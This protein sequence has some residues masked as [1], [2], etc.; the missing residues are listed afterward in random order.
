MK[1]LVLFLLS[2]SV[3]SPAL[4]QTPIDPLKLPQ[5]ESGSYI[6]TFGVNYTPDGQQRLF[7]DEFG[8]P[9]TTTRFDQ[10][11]IFSVSGSYSFN[12][13]ISIAGGLNSAIFFRSEKDEFADSNHRHTETDTNYSGALSLEYRLAPKGALDPRISFGVSYPWAA[14]VQGSASLLKDPVILSA[15]LGYYKSL[16]NSGDSLT[17]GL[18]AGFVANEKITFSGTANYTVPV[19][20]TDLPVTSIG[21]RTG[22]SLDP[23]GNKELGLRTTLSVSGRETKLGFGI[24][25]GGRGTISRRSKNLT[26]SNNSNVE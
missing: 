20:N 5:A 6:Y 21:F 26:P 3:T 18:G 4:A 11:L 1:K 13:N 10:N 12:E 8:N 2:F 14:N 19:G 15:S 9:F 7:L 17:V 23:K 25:F 16:E 24:E 22:Y